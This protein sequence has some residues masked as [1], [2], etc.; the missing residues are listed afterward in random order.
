M[1]HR[2]MVLAGSWYPAGRRACET[3]IRDYWHDLPATD[4]PPPDAPLRLGVVP[5]AGWMF[6]GRLAAHVFHALHPDE[7]VGL[8]IVLGGHLRRGDPVVAMVEGDWETPFGPLTLHEAIRPALEDLP[9]I[10]FDSE[11]RVSPDNSVEVQ[12]PLVRYAFPQAELVALRVPP[13]RLAAEVGRRLAAYVAERERPVAVVASTDLTHYGPNYDF[14]PHGRG[15]EALR[16][17]VEENDPAFIAALEAG[18][19]AGILET[20]GQRHNACS[21]GGTVAVNEIAHTNGLRFSLLG[22]ATSR[23]V[24]NDDEPNFVG[25]AAGVYR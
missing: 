21:P 2:R 7:D 14:E 13:S 10:V 15:P 18:D 4:G 6:S 3:Q 22:H 25:Y 17:V 24:V 5:H 16:W 9:A 23:A 1:L 11:R 19:S 12:L 20:A 8:A